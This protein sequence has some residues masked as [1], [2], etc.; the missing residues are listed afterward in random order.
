MIHPKLSSTRALCCSLALFPLIYVLTSKLLIRFLQMLQQTI[1]GTLKSSKNGVRSY[2]IARLCLFQAVLLL[3]H[4][5]TMHLTTVITAQLC[6]SPK[7]T[8]FIA[9][10]MSLFGAVKTSQNGVC[11]YTIARLCLFQAVLLLAHHYTTRLTTVN[12]ALK[13]Q[14]RKRTQFIATDMSADTAV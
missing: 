6:R 9:T 2:T 7:R 11:S 4:H 8:Q 14:S 12:T 5:Y 10:D 13:C 3:A 1:L